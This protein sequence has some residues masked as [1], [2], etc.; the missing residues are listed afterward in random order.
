MSLVYPHPDLSTPA[1]NDRIWRYLSFTKFAAMLQTECLYFRRADRFS[2]KWEG[3]IPNW[4]LNWLTAH[5]TLPN[6]A[7]GATFAEHFRN[8]EICRQYLNCWCRSPFESAAMWSIYTTSEEGV[9]VQSTVGRFKQSLSHASARE[10][11]SQVNIMIGNVDYADHTNW[12]PPPDTSAD[13]YA[14]PY[15][16]KRPSFV[17]EQEFR[18]KIDGA[19]VFAN[20]QPKPDGINVAVKLRELIECVYISPGADPWF[21]DVVDSLLQRY[22]LEGVSVEH[23]SLDT[24]R[25]M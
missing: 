11:N 10:T 12:Q 7:Q 2:D 6:W 20:D 19:N 17:Y 25:P 21:K 9:A 24:D 23:T 4:L 5:V 15:F 22:G 14:I 1:D 8:V 16:L 3:V 13:V 18:A